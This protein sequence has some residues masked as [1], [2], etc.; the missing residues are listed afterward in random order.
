MVAVLILI[1]TQ[2]L[3][4]QNCVEYPE[5]E[6]AFCTACVPEGWTSE[7]SSPDLA[8][9]TIYP[10]SPSESPS[11][12]NV[13]HLFSNGSNDIEAVSTEFTIDDFVPG[14]EYYFGLFF[15][16]CGPHSVE[17]EITINGEEYT[18]DST[19]EWENIELCLEPES[20]DMEIYITVAPYATG[21]I[22]N[23][24]LDTG[25][26]DPM[27]CCTL[28]A[29]LDEEFFELCPGESVDILGDIFGETG[30]VDVEWTSDP[31]SGVN[32]LEDPE[33][34]NT[35]LSIPENF[36]FEGEAI[37]Y[38]VM[39]EDAD[40]SITREFELEIRPSEM[41]EFDI[42]LCEV[43]EDY[44]LP[45]VSLNEYSGS[46]EGNMDF[47]E[48]GGEVHEYTF[49]FDPG[50]DNCVTE[51]TFEYLIHEEEIVTFE[52]ETSYCVNDDDTYYFPERSEERIEGEWDEDK[53]TPDELGV[54]THVFTFYPDMLEHCANEYEI[55]IVV[56]G[57]QEL[58]FDILTDYCVQGD[59][60]FLP[61]TSL[62]G[63]QGVWDR[64]FIDL[65]I[66]TENGVL[67]FSN[68]D[69][70]ACIADYVFEYS[71]SSELIPSFDNP[72][73][74]CRANQIIIPDSMSQD[75]YL[76][77]WT[78]D[79]FNPDTATS[80]FIPLV[81]TPL[82]DSIN[83]VGVFQDT[84]F[85]ADQ[86][87]PDF[88]LESQLC[89]DSGP[90][91]LPL[92]S[93][94]GITGSWNISSLDTDA[95]SPGIYDINFTPDLS[96]CA[97]EFNGTIEILDPS[98]FQLEFD[99]PI[100]VCQFSEVIMLPG[101][102][103]NGVSG[104]WSQIEVD[105]SV[106]ME[107]IVLVFSPEDN[108]SCYLD[109]SHTIYIQEPEA[110][111]FDL[112]VLLCSSIGV[113]EFPEVSLNGISGD[114]LLESYDPSANSDLVLNNVFTPDDIACFSEIE[115]D[116]DVY[117]FSDME[118]VT[119]DATSCLND[120]GLF[121]I[122]GNSRDIEFSIDGGQTWIQSNLLENLAPGSYQVDVRY[123]STECVE[124]FDVQIISP[125]A[126]QII[127]LV[128][129]SIKDCETN[130]A[131]LTSI[132]NSNDVEFSLNG[133]MNWQ[134]S[135][136]FVDLVAGTYQI[137]ARSTLFSDCA[138]SLSF[139]I[140]PI[141][142]T[143]IVDVELQHVSDC[144]IEDGR[145]VIDALGE[146]LEYSIDGGTSWQDDNEFEDLSGGMYLVQVRSKILENCG[147]ELEVEIEFPEYPIIADIEIVDLSSCS[148]SNGSIEITATGSDLE[149]SIDG[150]TSWQTSS[151]FLG[152]SH[153]TY[154]VVV[155]L[156]TTENCLITEVVTINAPQLPVL[157]EIVVTDVSSCMDDNGAIEIEAEG[158][159]LEFSIDAGVSWSSTPEFNGLAS[160]TYEL[161]IRESDFTDCILQETFE[162]FGPEEIEV[163]ETIYQEASSCETSDAVISLVLN[164]DDLEYSIDNG[165]NWQ[166]DAVFD[167]LASGTYEIL[168]RDINLTDCIISLIV[169]VIDPM[170]PC[171]DLSISFKTEPVDCLNPTSGSITIESIEGYIIEGSYELTWENGVVGLFID[172]LTEGWHSFIVD[173]DRN[174]QLV[175]SVYIDSFDPVS[176]D[177]LSYDQD[178]DEL[179]SIEV[180]NFMG[181]A[182][183]P[184]YSIDG[185][186]FQEN[187][188][189][190]NLTAQEY[191]VLVEDLFN[192]FGE[193]S[194]EV[195]D[196]S[197]LEVDLPGIDTIEAGESVVLNPLINQMTIDSFSWQPSIGILNP[198]ELIAEVAPE[199]TTT[200]IL[201]IFFGQCIE[202]RQVTV[203]VSPRP[204]LY[205]P[206]IFSPNGD[207]NNDY[208]LI[209]SNPDLN[210]TF[211]SFRIFDRWGNMVFENENFQAN[212][213]ESGWDGR[214][215]DV[216]VIPGVYV[217]T[218]AYNYKGEDK[219][220]SGTVT[221]VR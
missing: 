164:R 196:A 133:G 194:T 9:P 4:G 138:D 125:N 124:T 130:T 167:Q 64:A 129:D 42:F 148:D 131:S 47:D 10:C 208:F 198:G 36:E 22:T 168:I 97:T 48:I 72:D 76:G 17:L 135:G 166:D 75:G 20:A 165:N 155:R 95:E 210:I 181:G 1:F 39:I 44:E 69:G 60:I 98:Q 134:A 92:T 113:Y 197:N 175:D 65:N 180:V 140:D 157:N 104:S 26:C 25:I 45:L 28:G 190:A 96:E 200:Y 21:S 24:L 61:D 142:I 178:C 146:Q 101:T 94:N 62:E 18:F 172:G 41:P 81:W 52:Y 12:G 49:T 187:T 137:I 139:D 116:I 82:S 143:E 57:E 37:T 87:I 63:V 100:S 184:N 188:V 32:Y 23:T 34:I 201:T 145:I 195:N 115:V 16:S 106:V 212:V 132:A 51:W 206:G 209:M 53:F 67:V 173:Y 99:L 105:P 186:N 156:S 43:Y 91:Q 6:G 199:E 117:S 31:S 93:L 38:T 108:E 77:Y 162:T 114:W 88:N 55:E 147:R 144:V 152:L 86:V 193:Q 40:C 15:L 169:E 182:G 3:I 205:I 70:N 14:E 33:S 213:Q 74:V 217:Y 154:E 78:P 176:F 203:D 111:E 27:F 191:Q 192:C 122:I 216:D 121:E 123:V 85:I 118:I 2:C 19:E 120:N 71:V 84:V 202:T 163:L 189:F 35:V 103:E 127:E 119:R 79:S 153:G 204:D 221:V 170:C 215:N 73:L 50:Q 7:S 58:S 5:I 59:S 107:L 150:G 68:T 136:D 54:G 177:L 214:F 109:Y 29:E 89:D 219:M 128:I 218:L 56:F 174:C 158:L 179:G 151:S 183:Q 220:V 66:E 149:Y 185:I 160:G 46:W 80:S 102:S 11:G 112:P 159:N 171:N 207:N 126:I 141:V 90:Y 13:I 8:D 110:P 161:L 30:S 83:C 211:D